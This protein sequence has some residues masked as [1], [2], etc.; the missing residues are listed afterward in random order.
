[1][2][3]VRD[4]KR[5]TY[6]DEEDRERAYALVARARVCTSCGRDLGDNVGGQQA[7]V[8]YPSANRDSEDVYLVVVCWD[9]VPGAIDAVRQADRLRSLDREAEA[10]EVDSTREAVKT[11]LAT[12]THETLEDKRFAKME[13]HALNVGERVDTFQADD[14]ANWKQDSPDL[15]DARWIIQ[16]DANERLAEAADLEEWARHGPAGEQL[17]ATCPNCGRPVAGRG[18]STTHALRGGAGYSCERRP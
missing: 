6:Q 16:R 5:G 17:V 9:C 4:P 8:E 14:R 12:T 3:L 10:A 2:Y 15:E 11:F 1:M 13:A 18:V 7:A